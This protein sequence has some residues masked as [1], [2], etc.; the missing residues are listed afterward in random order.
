ME[1]DDDDYDYLFKIV[2]IGKEISQNSCLKVIQVLEKRTCFPGLL[3]I[4]FIQIH[5]QLLEWNLP[6]NK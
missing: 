1:A 3:M 6:L 5:R 2:L 4:N